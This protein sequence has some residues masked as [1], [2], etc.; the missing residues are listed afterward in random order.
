MQ[1]ITPALQQLSNDDVVFLTAYYTSPLL[2]PCIS[3]SLVGKRWHGGKGRREI[4]FLRSLSVAEYFVCTASQNLFPLFRSLST[5]VCCLGDK[6]EWFPVVLRNWACDQNLA[7]WSGAAVSSIQWTRFC[8]VW[9][10]TRVSGSQFTHTVCLKCLFSSS[11]K[12]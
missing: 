6:D 12:Q 7:T 11:N 5:A 10:K 2:Q 1:I 9:L 3:Y 4:S 8:V